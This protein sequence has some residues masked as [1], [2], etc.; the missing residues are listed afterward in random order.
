MLLALEK[1]ARRRRAFHI[2][3]LQEVENGL[4]PWRYKR[5]E[6]VSQ[7]ERALGLGQK[8]CLAAGPSVQCSCSDQS[9]TRRVC[10]ST[11]D[12]LFVPLCRFPAVLSLPAN[13]LL[14][15][16]LLERQQPAI[17]LQEAP[18]PGARR[19]WRQAPHPGL[20]LLLMCSRHLQQLAAKAGT[21]GVGYTSGKQPRRVGREAK[22][23]G[24]FVWRG[25][26]QPP[27]VLCSSDS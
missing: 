7:K 2:S 26:K 19:L 27:Q 15:R 13:V 20:A 22:H 6:H 17:A 3:K 11:A 4:R 21:T 18:G 14:H 1:T 12:L 25:V 23:C 8:A 24:W 9:D 16:C 10:S 5:V